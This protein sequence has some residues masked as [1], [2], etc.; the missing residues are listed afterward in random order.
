MVA[1]SHIKFMGLLTSCTIG[2]LGKGERWR[3]AQSKGEERECNFD[4]NMFLNSY[5]LKLCLKQ[6]KLFPYIIMF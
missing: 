5:M 4:Q 6:T 2:P 3:G 1:L